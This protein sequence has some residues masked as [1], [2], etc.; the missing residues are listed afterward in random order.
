MSH[1]VTVAVV[2]HLERPEAALVARRAVSWLEE[3]GNRVLMPLDDARA[4]ALGPTRW[5]R[6]RD[7]PVD[8]AISIGG[9]G[10]MLRGSS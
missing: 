4:I 2:T 3:H 8:S 7:P 9:D 10:T 5:A 1:P 6:G